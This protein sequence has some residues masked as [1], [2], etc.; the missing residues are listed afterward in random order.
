VYDYEQPSHRRKNA[1]RRRELSVPPKEKQNEF[2][3]SLDVPKKQKVFFFPTAPVYHQS[4]V[5]FIFPS[6]H[7][8]FPSFP[9]SPSLKRREAF[10]NP[11][12]TVRFPGIPPSDAGSFSH[13]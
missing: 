5:F 9:F 7:R 2:F 11:D 10:H 4:P 12:L 1:L 6:P 8:F 3:P 13:P